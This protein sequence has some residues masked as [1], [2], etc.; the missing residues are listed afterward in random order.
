MAPEQRQMDLG[1][2]LAGDVIPGVSYRFGALLEST[3]MALEGSIEEFGLT[4]IFQLIFIQKK[5]GI[6]TLTREKAVV[7]VHFKEGRIIR[8]GDENEDETFGNALI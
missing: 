1:A 5:E 4:E 2:V 3:V 7:C 8:A 6:L